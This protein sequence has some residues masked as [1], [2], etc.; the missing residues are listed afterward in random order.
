MLSE[1]KPGVPV[2]QPLLLPPN[3]GYPCYAVLGFLQLHVQNLKK[4]C[5][6]QTQIYNK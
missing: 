6:L 1:L 3:T 2:N 5:S 4:R